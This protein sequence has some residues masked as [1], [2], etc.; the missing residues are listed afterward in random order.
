MPPDDAAQKAMED[1][2]KDTARHIAD[3]L[4]SLPKANRMTALMKL[5]LGDRRALAQYAPGDLRDRL[6]A[7]FSPAEKETY[8]A[9][10]GPAN[11]VVS[12]LQQSKILRAMY[13]ER[14]LQEVMTDFWFNHFNVFI[15][16]DPP[17]FS[18]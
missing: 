5:P 18:I 10:N 16:K 17:C 2:A 1:A 14:Q 7:D 3:M 13:S 11:V 15:N 6:L 9:M 12:E 8:L 4:L